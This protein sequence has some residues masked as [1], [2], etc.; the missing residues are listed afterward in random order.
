MDELFNI[1]AYFLDRHLEAGEGYRA[2]LLTRDGLS[3]YEDVWELSNRAA[4]V[5]RD[6]GV[7]RRDRVLLALPSGPDLVAA[8]FGAARLGAMAVPVNPRSSARELLYFLGD[9]R[10]RVLL[11]DEGALDELKQIRERFRPEGLLVVGDVPLTWSWQRRLQDAEPHAETAMT[12]P[13]DPAFILYHS[14]G[15]GEW[16][17]VFQPHQELFHASDLLGRRRLLV[18]PDDRIY[19]TAPLYS[20]YGLAA[21]LAVP[22][23]AGASAVLEP[24]EPRPDVVQATIA[25]FRPTLLFSVPRVFQMLLHAPGEFNLA[26]V[27]AAVSAGQSR[28]VE[29]EQRFRERFDCA[30]LDASDVAMLAQAPAGNA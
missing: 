1:A 26:G 12:A 16:R 29:L 14:T 17:K 15:G 6:L 8:I 2:A 28:P 20:A 3:T 25:R 10:A 30:M 22:L 4:G 23:S 27:R 21:T 11:V 13:Q 24:R 19:C 7:G 9:S 18:E 5:F